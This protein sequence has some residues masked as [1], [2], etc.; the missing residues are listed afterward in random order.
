MHT[1]TE[2]AAVIDRIGSVGREE[3]AESAFLV[4]FNVLYPYTFLCL[5]SVM[6]AQRIFF[7]IYALARGCLTLNRVKKME[8]Q[9]WVTSFLSHLEDMHDGFQTYCLIQRDSQ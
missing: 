8:E 3:S 2:A 1:S 6:S 4:F 5:S 9:A 7:L